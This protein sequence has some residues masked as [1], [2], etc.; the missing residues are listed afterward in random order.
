MHT[1]TSDLSI[2]KQFSRESDQSLMLRKLRTASSKLAPTT[3]ENKRF[4]CH[5][6]PQI[7]VSFRAKGLNLYGGGG[8]PPENLKSKRLI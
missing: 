5:I 2:L 1:L 4:D 8:I 3:I 6:A 7:S